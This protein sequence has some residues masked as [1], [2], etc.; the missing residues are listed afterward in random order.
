MKTITKLVALSTVSLACVVAACGGDDEGTTGTQTGATTGG[1]GTGGTNTGT[2][3]GGGTGGGGGDPA[4]PTLGTQID[5]MGRA[6]VAT[7]TYDRFLVDQATHDASV[8]T[9][10]QDASPANWATYTTNVATQI[11]ILDGLEGTCGNQL[12]YGNPLANPATD[13]PGDGNEVCY[14]L[15]G[16][17]LSNDWIILKPNGADGSGYLGVESDFVAG[18]GDS[19][20]GR[21]PA[22]DVIATSYTILAG[23]D[24]DDGVTAPA[25]SQVELFPYLAAPN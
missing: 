25:Q 10:N 23:V 1:G 9:W 11:G 15:L 24:F 18:S 8:D 20:G 3:G 16:T 21:M 7:A 19:R 14:G 17:V 5:R 4:P 6:A 22:D 13:C 2:T 12:I